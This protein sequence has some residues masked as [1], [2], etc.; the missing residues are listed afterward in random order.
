[1]LIY[2]G[3]HFFRFVEKIEGKVVQEAEQQSTG[4]GPYKAASGNPF[5]EEADINRL[6]PKLNI[7]GTGFR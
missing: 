7:E 4:T 3:F 2:Q 5:E 1:M 6:A